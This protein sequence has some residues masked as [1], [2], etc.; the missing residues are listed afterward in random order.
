MRLFLFCVPVCLFVIM[1][2]L[3]IY[4][5]VALMNQTNIKS[6]NFG[7]SY[8]YLGIKQALDIKISEIK[9]LYRER[10]LRRVTIL[11]RSRLN[12]RFLFTSINIWALPTMTYSFGI[13]TW[14]I[15]DLQEM[16]R[17]LRAL[18]TKYGIHPSHS[19][20]V[21]LYL[22]RHLGGPAQSGENSPRRD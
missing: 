5:D 13:I 19:S 11:L 14:S 1:V 6:L 21:R 18:L 22:Q 7:D 10:L 15:T 8:K 3:Y 17:A 16:D 9:K 2:S 4:V 20:I 12:S